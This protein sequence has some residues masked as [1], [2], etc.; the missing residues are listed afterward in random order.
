M[1]LQ[2]EMQLLD[3]LPSMSNASIKM[4]PM[5]NSFFLRSISDICWMRHGVAHVSLRISFAGFRSLTS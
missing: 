2:Y 3:E 5:L 1:T 4:R